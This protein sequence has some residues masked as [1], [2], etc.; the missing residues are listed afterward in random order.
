MNRLSES[1][2]SYSKALRV[3]LEEL[4]HRREMVNRMTVGGMG[5]AAGRHDASDNIPPERDG[6]IMALSS[7]ISRV[8]ADLGKA[9]EIA[10]RYGDARKEYVA[11]MEILR[12]GCHVTERDDAR[13]RELKSN[14]ARMKRAMDVDHDRKKHAAILA[15]AYHRLERASENDDNIVDRDNARR[16]LISCLERCMRIERDSIGEGSYGYAKLKLKLSKAKFEYGDV[17]GGT[18]DADAAAR[19][20]KSVLGSSH[21][22]VGAASSFV[23]GAYERR[24]NM[25]YDALIRSRIPGGDEDGGGK[26]VPLTPECKSMF[27]KALEWYADALGPMRYKYDGDNRDDH[28]DDRHDR[29]IRPDVGDV[30]RKISK[31]YTRRGNSRGSAVDACHRALEAYGAG[32]IIDPTNATKSKIMGGIGGRIASSSYGDF[33]PDAAF[34]WRDLACLHLT[35][36][37]Y[38]DAVYAAERAVESSRMVLKGAHCDKKGIDALPSSALYIAGDGYV[39]MRRYEDATRSYREAYTEYR[40]VGHASGDGTVDG[41]TIL[42]KLGMTFYH[43]GMLDEAKAHLMDALRAERSSK[44]RD[45]VTGNASGL[46]LLLSD[47]GMVHS[48]CFLCLMQ[49]RCVYFVRRRTESQY[50]LFRNTSQMRRICRGHQGIAILPQAVR[51]SRSFGSYRP[52]QEGEATV[53]GGVDECPK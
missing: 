48:K 53:Q 44:D 29:V 18:V 2:E 38:G 43:R 3:G 31:L 11:G 1:V 24:G 19:T 50:L 30:F 52:G 28:R 26:Q 40:R 34:V 20:I 14:A 36:R 9:L 27:T 4:T 42:G 22:I 12:H 32:G 15:S 49:C 16:S 46:P 13:A 37:E 47:I 8:H 17:E 10:Q 6:M 35:G 33:H 45:G 39:G 7:S 41:A 25:M 21:A 51:R 5:M 23:A